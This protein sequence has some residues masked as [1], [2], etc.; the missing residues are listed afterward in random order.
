MTESQDDNAPVSPQGVDRK[1]EGGCPVMHDSAAAEGS[2]SENPVI[3]SPTP[4][5]AGARTR[6]RTGG[7]TP[8][9][10][11]SC[12]RTPPRATRWAPTSTTPRPSPDSTSTRSRPTSSRSC[13]ARR[14][15]GRP[16]STTTAGC[17]S[18][19][20]GTRPAPTASTTAAEVP[21]TAGSGSRPLNSWPDNANLDKARRLLWPVKQKY[22]TQLSWADLLVL[23]GNVAL[24]DMGLETFGFGFGRE[25][26]WEPEEIFWGPE[27]TWL[28]DE[29]YAGERELEESLGAVQMGLIYV[30]PEGPQRQPRPAGLRP[31]HPRDLRPDGDERRGDGRPD[32]RR[33]HLRQ[34][35]RC[36]RRRPG[37][38][39]ARGCPAGGAGA[40][41]EERLRHRQ[42]RRRGHLRSRGHLD[43][44]PG[45]VEQRLLRL[46]LRP[47]VGA[48]QEPGRRSPVGRQG[49]RRGHPRSDRRTPRSVVPPC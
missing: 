29:R 13:T 2:E 6:S 35:P 39:R 17:S 15:G 28:G 49:R 37:R 4:R 38:A 7:P 34:D 32:R 33:A 16:T 20:A 1:A 3:D 14:T 19:S 48:H 30:N 5:P 9:T 46:P 26:T 12:T 8:W 43:P 10:S 21:A 23:A 44:H 40:G 25:D 41:L 18:G 11:R 36:G 27:D 22:G 47:R 24:D 31:R 45:A 42:G